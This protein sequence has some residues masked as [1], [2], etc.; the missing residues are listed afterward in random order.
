M[1]MCRTATSLMARGRA[2]RRLATSRDVEQIL[3]EMDADKMAAI[4]ALCPTINDLAIVAGWSSGQ[5]ETV[6]ELRAG[7]KRAAEALYAILINDRDEPAHA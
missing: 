3:G 2:L 5:G 4:L 6:V 1:P 7:V